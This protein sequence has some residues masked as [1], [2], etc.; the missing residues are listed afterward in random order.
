MKKLKKEDLY[1]LYK[2]CLN[3]VKRKPAEFFLFKR[4]SKYA[5][6]CNWTDIE[7]D[8]RCDLLSTAYHECVHYIEPKWCETQVL[9]TESRLRNSLAYLDHARFL[10]HLSSK[11]YKS[12][13]Q[14]HIL[15]LPKKRRKNQNRTINRTKVPWILSIQD[16]NY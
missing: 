1:K 15:S 12:E 16:D 14:R 10:K 2:R 13:L 5:G 8:H 3:L 9:Y 6:S 11:L 4:M 7:L